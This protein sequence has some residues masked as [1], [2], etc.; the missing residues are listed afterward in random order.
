MSKLVRAISENGGAALSVLDSTRIV[1]AMEGYHHPSAV[2]SAALGRL[3][4]GAALMAASLKSTRDA[5]TLRVKGGG[6]AGLLLA[7]ADGAGNVKGYAENPLAD[8]PGRPDGKLDVGGVVGRNGL[9]TVIRDAG[10][11][12]PYIGQVPLVSGEIAEDLTAYY[13]ASEQIPTVCALGVLVEKDLTIRRAGGYLLQLLP[14]ATEEE[15][16]LLERNIAGMESLTRL[17]D[18]GKTAH[19]IIGQLLDGFHPQLLDESA[20]QYRCDCSLAR[21]ERIYRSLG[22][23]ELRR[24]AAEQEIVEIKCQFC[25]RAYHL[26]AA[27]YLTAEG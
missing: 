27:D 5:L 1:A 6:P 10:M 26:R 3:L 21:T 12:E 25:N 15:I 2:V 23:Q 19:D 11:K 20:A 24:I 13:A 7:V 4:T 22:Q 8:L 9:L 18:A 17:L 14:G 16:S